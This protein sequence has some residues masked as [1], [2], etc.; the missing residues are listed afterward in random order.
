[1][2]MEYD[3]ENIDSYNQGISRVF[4]DLMFIYNAYFEKLKHQTALKFIQS[5]EVKISEICKQIVLE[6]FSN[7]EN[8]LYGN[9]SSI[10]DFIDSEFSNSEFNNNLSQSEYLICDSLINCY[11]LKKI[12]EYS[13]KYD[14]ISYSQI[15]MYHYQMINEMGVANGIISYGEMIETEK[16]SSTA[17]NNAMKRWSKQDKIRYDKKKKFLKIM[18]EEGFTTYNEAAEHIKMTVENKSH[19]DYQNTKNKPLSFDTITRWLSQ[20]DKGNFS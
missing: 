15:L 9:T 5:Y 16:L 14:A 2:V 7:K 10:D 3:I 11:C 13:Y 20:A 17:Q 19:P 8:C 18:K 1:M 6:N 12:I 4:D